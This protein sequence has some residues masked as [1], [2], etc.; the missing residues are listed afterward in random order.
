MR[1]PSTRRSK[2]SFALRT[3]LS[4][5]F[6]A[7]CLI[8]LIC[9]L[10]ISKIYESTTYSFATFA[11]AAPRSTAQTHAIP[12]FIYLPSLSLGLPLVQTSITHG[13]WPTQTDAASHLASSSTPGEHGN[14]VIYGRN[15]EDQFGL[16][17]SLR[18]GDEIIVSNR[19]G[20]SY[21]YEV[22]DLG[23]FFPNETSLI[24]TTNKETLTLYTPYGFAGLKRFL[25]R[26][27]PTTK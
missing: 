13:V 23:V 19:N 14:V 12:T 6:G 15:T 8:V 27:T 5:R 26:A 1:L 16:L 10:L 20:D 21:S 4:L 17:T 25:V 3:M 9:S 7:L 24:S 2:A 22:T 18:K 11:T